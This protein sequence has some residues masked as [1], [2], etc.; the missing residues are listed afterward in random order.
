[1]L[2]LTILKGMCLH[3]VTKLLCSLGQKTLRMKF[4]R[5]PNNHVGKLI[6]KLQITNTLMF[7]CYTKSGI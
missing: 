7:L 2:I 4:L 6:T 3:K 5:K 1:M